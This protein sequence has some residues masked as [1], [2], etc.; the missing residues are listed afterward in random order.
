V[1][2]LRGVLAASA[3]LLAV[4]VAFLFQLIVGSCAEIVLHLVLVRGF[5]S[6]HLPYSISG[7]RDG[8]RGPAVCRSAL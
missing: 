7:Q 5:S 1:R 2:S 4:P 8:Y 3:C 6:Q